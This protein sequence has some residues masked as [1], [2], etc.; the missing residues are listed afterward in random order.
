MKQRKKK[1]V[2]DFGINIIASGI[3][4]IML[5]IVIYPLL[6]SRYSDLEYG[7]ILTIM[8]IMNIIIVTLGNSLNNVRLIQNKE[9]LD[10]NVT[11]DFNLLVIF[12]LIS[13][14]TG[15]LLAR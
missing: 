8:G 13:A 4:T 6:A 15:Q 1:I 7:T 14:L 3:L 10:K 9:Y 12:A 5:Q 2:A 11:G